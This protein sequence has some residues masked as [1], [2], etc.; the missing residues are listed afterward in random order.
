MLAFL[1]VSRNIGKDPQPNK[2]ADVTKLRGATD[3]KEG[4]KGH[5]QAQNWA[6]ENLKR[7]NKA[8]CKMLHLS[9]GNPRHKYSLGEELTETSL[10]EKDLG[11]LVDGHEPSAGHEPAVCS[12]SPEGQ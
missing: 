10:E 7:L 9:S 2:Y 6:H 12:C 3:T 4:L 5:G 11:I 8:N 1:L